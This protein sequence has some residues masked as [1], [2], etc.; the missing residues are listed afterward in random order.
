MVRLPSFNLQTM[1]VL[2]DDAVLRMFRVTDLHQSGPG[3]NSPS[4]IP[5]EDGKFR[6][7]TLTMLAFRASEARCITVVCR[8]A[9]LS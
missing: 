2:T 7:V 3:R 4:Q 8:C 6:S 9:R 5:V 1:L